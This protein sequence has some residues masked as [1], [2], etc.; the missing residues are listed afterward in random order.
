[1]DDCM[2]DTAK[3]NDIFQR[4]KFVYQSVEDIEVKIRSAK[5]VTANQHEEMRAS[6][7]QRQ[8]SFLFEKAR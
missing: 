6:L 8:P 3:F 5:V 2:A 1:M 4:T 7:M